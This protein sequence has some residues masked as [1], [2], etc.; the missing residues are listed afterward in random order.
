MYSMHKKIIFKFKLYVHYRLRQFI[1][2]NSKYFFW[3]SRSTHE[4]CEICM[5]KF[6]YAVLFFWGF[7]CKKATLV[8]M[9][10]YQKKLFNGGQIHWDS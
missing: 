2:I 6:N 1:Q 8:Q 5:Y 9:N 4:W 10:L 3:K 7:F